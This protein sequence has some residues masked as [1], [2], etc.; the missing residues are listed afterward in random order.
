MAETQAG[1]KQSHVIIRAWQDFFKLPRHIKPCP[2][3]Q[4]KPDHRAPHMTIMDFR[5]GPIGICCMVRWDLTIAGFK[6]CQAPP[7]AA[8]DA[9]PGQ[10]GCSACNILFH[11]SRGFMVRMQGFL[12]EIRRHR[13]RRQKQCLL[14]LWIRY[15]IV[16][17]WHR[18]RRSMTTG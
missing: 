18:Q 9:E 8:L 5:L 4:T 13:H 17:L 15:M 6:S 7:H 10:V 16:R 12:M 11:I 14:A 3:A 2:L 1:M